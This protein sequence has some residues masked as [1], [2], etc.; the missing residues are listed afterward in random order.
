MT[1]PEKL[2]A[3]TR[4]NDQ[5]SIPKVVLNPDPDSRPDTNELYE[6]LKADGQNMENLIPDEYVLDRPFVLDI[7]YQDGGYV[8][9]N[10]FLLSSMGS[11]TAQFFLQLITSEILVNK[12]TLFPKK[13]ILSPNY[14]T[15]KYPN[16]LY[17]LLAN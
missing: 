12:N 11:F 2:F 8:L 7:A 17:F 14:V 4:R 5:T 1:D 13:P 6:L 9:R 3:V 15:D 16:T 10:L